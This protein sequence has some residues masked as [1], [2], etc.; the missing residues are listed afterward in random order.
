VLKAARK[1]GVRHYYLE[2]EHP[3]AVAQMQQSLRYL[4]QIRF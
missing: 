3:N 2:E 1:H 4:E